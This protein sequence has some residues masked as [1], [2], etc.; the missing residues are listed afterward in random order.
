MSIYT[1]LGPILRTYPKLRVLRGY[2]PTRP[3]T[4]Q[5]SLPVQSG[6]TI[7]SGQVISQAWNSGLTRFEWVLGGSGTQPTFFAN[8]DSVD[9]D[10]ISADSLPALPSYGQFVLQTGYFDAG[11]Y[12]TGTPLTFSTGTPG[13]VAVGSYGTSSAAGVP[14]IGYADGVE[15]SSNSAIV[16]LGAPSH[17]GYAAFAPYDSSATDLS[18]LQL[19]TAWIPVNPKAAA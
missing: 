11:T 14:I 4:L 15:G 8:G 12:N 5:K 3:T 10:I 2:D 7:Y 16:N 1:T 6:V 9:P 13:N 17:A 19:V 18:V